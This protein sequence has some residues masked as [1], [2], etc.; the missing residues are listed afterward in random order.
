MQTSALPSPQWG[1]VFGWR[2][3]RYFMVLTERYQ[4]EQYAATYCRVSGNPMS[5]CYLERCDVVIGYYEADQMVG[6]VA[7][8]TLEQQPLR[9]FTE[10]L[11]DQVDDL[12]RGHELTVTDLLEIAGFYIDGQRAMI[13][14]RLRMNLMLMSK[15]QELAIKLQKTHVVAG[16]FETGLQIEQRKILTLMLYRNTTNLKKGRVVE[17]YAGHRKRLVPAGIWVIG[18]KLLKWLSHK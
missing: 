8:S 15:A 16:A 2:R 1:E 6:G 13:W 17:I 4:F 10:L 3:P 7:F 18:Q 11:P 12:L 9:V 14:D 5:V